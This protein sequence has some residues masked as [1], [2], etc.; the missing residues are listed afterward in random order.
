MSCA[1]SDFAFACE[2]E[3]LKASELIGAF[4]KMTPEQ[5]SNAKRRLAA[6][7]ADMADGLPRSIP[8]SAVPKLFQIARMHYNRVPNIK[9]VSQAWIN[10]MKQP[11]APMPQ[12]A[13]KIEYIPLNNTD[14]KWRALAAIRTSIAIGGHLEQMALPRD[15]KLEVVRYLEPETWMGPLLF[16][17]PSID[18]TRAA[19]LIVNRQW[20]ERNKDVPPFWGHWFAEYNV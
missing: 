15:A 9:D 2:K 3:L 4:D 16:E 6:I 12:D 5:E 13:P 19:A 10:H 8:L 17:S 20:A 1:L 18:E 14:A 11:D 7:A